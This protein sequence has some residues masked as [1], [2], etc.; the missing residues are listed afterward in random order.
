[1]QQTREL[2]YYHEE[3]RKLGV[4]ILLQAQKTMKALGPINS[5]AQAEAWHMYAER[6]VWFGW[7]RRARSAFTEEVLAY[8]TREEPKNLDSYI[9]IYRMSAADLM[10]V[11]NHRLGLER[12]RIALKAAEDDPR[13]DKRHLG[14]GQ[15]VYGEALLQAG[16]P[17]AAEVQL[18][19]AIATLTKPGSV[20]RPQYIEYL[21]GRLAEAGTVR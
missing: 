15:V 7:E 6:M 8:R 2:T 9:G 3:H 10:S 16:D 5:D 12:Y 4:E 19:K 13:P 14:I 17:A 11:G 1:M 20:Q 18:A 21:R